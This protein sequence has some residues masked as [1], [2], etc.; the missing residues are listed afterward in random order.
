MGSAPKNTGLTEPA[1]A[2]IPRLQLDYHSFRNMNKI[3]C[4]TPSPFAGRSRFACFLGVHFPETAQRIDEDD[5]GVLHLEV[6][7]LKLASREAIANADWDTLRAHYAFIVALVDHGGDELRGALEV[8][9]LGSLFYGESAAGYAKARTLLPPPLAHA[10]ARV[11]THYDDQRRL[12]VSAEG[13]ILG[14]LTDV[15]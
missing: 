12:P 14:G 11:E 8:S 15:Q 4:M 2:G 3:L 1:I 5:F 13:I 10:L 9:Y 6:G 7:V